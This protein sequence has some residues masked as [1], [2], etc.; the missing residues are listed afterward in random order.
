M[1]V[2]IYALHL[3]FGGVERYVAT[4][5]NMLSKEHDVRIVS[6]YRT[7]TEP[8]FPIA[9]NVEIIY[10][11]EDLLPNNQA[12][13]T[14]IKHMNPYAIC[15]EACYAAY[16]LFQRRYQNKKAIKN[17]ESDVILST[18]IFHNRL[19]S[20]YASNHSIKITGEHNHP[21]GNTAYIK[22]VI[23]SCT[24][25]DY[26]IPIS[27]ALCELYEEA[28]TYP[29]KIKYIPFC[30]EKND[31]HG[32]MM[33]KEKS[34][35]NV[36]R[37]SPEKGIPDLIQVMKELIYTYHYPVTLQIIGSGEEEAK[38]CSLISEYQLEDYITLHGFQTKEYV[39]EQYRKANLYIM[40]SFTESFGIVLL[41]AMS[42][43]VPCIA[44]DSA[45]GSREIIDNGKDGYLIQDR[46][47]DAMC[48]MIINVLSDPERLEKLSVQALK[49][50]DMYSYERCEQAWL[51]F[52]EQ[53]QNT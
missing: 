31:Q 12:F 13:R 3:G 19:I 43:G 39:Y 8:A 53:L 5:A 48:K 50:A 41:E 15:K 27:K 26:F 30:I 33:A 35:I 20:K 22:K 34:L 40:T 28:F 14:A 4:I 7:T 29:I 24:N 17:D 32:Y 2:T 11:L 9:E 6:T 1:K 45:E 18:R 21:H 25:F 52:F 47:I 49:K 44:F 36:G 37:L 46:R 23:S 16:V 38:I 51:T 10:L 42:C